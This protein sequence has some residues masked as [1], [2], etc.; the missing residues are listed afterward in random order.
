MNK[1]LMICYYYPPVSD[2]G[3]LRSIAFSKNL[4]SFGYKPSVLTVSKADRGYCRVGVTLPPEGVKVYRTRSLFSP[5][6]WV[7]VANAVYARLR[8]ICKLPPS[9]GLYAFLLNIWLPDI[10][11]PWIPGA[12]LKG[13]HLEKEGFG[14]IYA[15]CS[16][17]SGAVVGAILKKRLG[18]PLI[19]DFR[20]PMT[21]RIHGRPESPIDKLKQC[22]EERLL[23]FCD[24]LILVSRETEER[25]LNTYPFL[26]GK[27]SVIYNGFDEA[28]LMQ[29]ERSRSSNSRFTLLYSGNFYHNLV[30]PEPFFEALKRVL[31]SGATRQESFLFRYVG[32]MNDWVR[33]LVKEKGLESVVEVTGFV[34]RGEV[35]KFLRDADAVLLRNYK[36]CITTKLYEGLAMGK[37]FLATVGPGEVESMVRKYSP[38]SVVVNPENTEAIAEG[39][40]VLY[41]RWENSEIRDK[42]SQSYLKENNWQA[43]TGRLVDVLDRCSKG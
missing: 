22:V 13:L 18:I 34:D 15:S 37:V 9:Y 31:Q 4:P 36:P 1:I 30:D 19:L 41:S 27:V 8:R 10:F 2:V 35:V 7:E 38:E 43:L 39:I 11:A 25:Y 6:S 21:N 12:V 24:H 40:R 28:F 26:E 17:L 42:A 3:A 16:P 29:E 5:G 20:D 14:T 33:M 23:R 32:A